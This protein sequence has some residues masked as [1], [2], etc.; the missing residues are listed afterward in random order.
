MS[1]GTIRSAAKVELAAPARRPGATTLA[2]FVVTRGERVADQVY[3]TLRR[4]IIMGEF[5][6]GIR[7]REVEVA[8]ALKVSRTPVREAISR[9]IGARLLRELPMGGVEVVD[10]TAELS[11]IYYIREA[12]ESCAARLAALRITEPQ[13]ARLDGLIA[14]AE[15]A[16]T[17][18]FDER[19]RINQEFHMTIAE[20]AASPRL[21]EMIGGFR[22]F[23]MNARWL[24]R[25]DRK[26]LSRALR[27]H[28]GIVAALRAGSSDRAERLVRQHL[29]EAYAKLLAEPRKARKR[30]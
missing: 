15:A 12:L 26:G 4:A 10:A 8:A 7:L 30:V 23:F 11:E 28:R 20:A 25:Y 29:K 21:I 5:Q 14:A 22:E 6:P 16:G 27:E 17:R 3:R 24:S 19:V 18:S 2:R 9:L 1:S 13:L